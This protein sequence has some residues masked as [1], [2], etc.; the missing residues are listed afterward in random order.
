MTAT[1]S[2][3]AAIDAQRRLDVLTEVL[4]E[5]RHAR[6]SLVKRLLNDGHR[7]NALANDIGVTEGTIRQIRDRK[8]RA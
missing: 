5:A 2:L 8:D 7:V 6:D 1:D 4:A 3:Q